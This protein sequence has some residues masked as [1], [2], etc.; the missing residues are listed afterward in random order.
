MIRLCWPLA[1]NDVQYWARAGWIDIRA[2]R[3]GILAMLEFVLQNYRSD[4]FLPFTGQEPISITIAYWI[5]INELLLI[6]ESLL[7]NYESRITR[8]E[9]REPIYRCRYRAPV[10]QAH[11]HGAGLILDPSSAEPKGVSLPLDRW[12][13]ISSPNLPLEVGFQFRRS[14]ITRCKWSETGLVWHP[15]LKP[16]RWRIRYWN[17]MLS[18]DCVIVWLIDWLQTDTE[19]TMFPMWFNRSRAFVNMS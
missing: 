5:I 13:P 19:L 7:M 18:S 10:E 12:E 8:A 15:M 17:T 14:E 4:L 3:R 2:R 6:N 1:R 9:L 11:F 16:K